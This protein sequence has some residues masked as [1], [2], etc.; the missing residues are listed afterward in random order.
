[1]LV[2]I[3]GAKALPE[4]WQNSQMPLRWIAAGMA[5]QPSSSAA[6]TATCTYPRCAQRSMRP[7]PLSHRPRRMPPD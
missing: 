1:M 6:S 3:D 4:R 5:R 2:V 7:S